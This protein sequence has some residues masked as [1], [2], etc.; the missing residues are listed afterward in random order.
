MSKYTTEDFGLNNQLKLS[1]KN[2]QEYENDANNN[3]LLQSNPNLLN[4]TTL[5]FN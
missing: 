3:S 4:E 2:E 5:D 1:I